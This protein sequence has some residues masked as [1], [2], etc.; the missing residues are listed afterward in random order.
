MQPRNT[1]PMVTVNIVRINSQIIF[2]S[3]NMGS[4]GKIKKEDF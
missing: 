4:E 2:S 3:N 1:R